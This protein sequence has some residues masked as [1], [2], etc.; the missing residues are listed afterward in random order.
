M[1]ELAAELIETV[2]VAVDRMIPV[3]LEVPVTIPIDAELTVPVSRTIPIQVEVPVVMDVPV[4]IPLGET[5][6]G[7]YLR[8][9]SESLRRMA[10]E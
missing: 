9:L 3:E 5:R 7:E 10:A 1:S 6:L 2:T 8:G 4:D